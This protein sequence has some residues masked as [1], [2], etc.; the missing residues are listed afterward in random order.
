[1]KLIVKWMRLLVAV[2][3]IVAV[4]ATFAETAMRV[5]VN[6]FNFF[7]YFTIQSNLIIAVV[8]LVTTARS[9]NDSRGSL[10]L[11]RACAT[12]Y[13][14]VVGIVYALLLAPLGAA[15]GVPLPWANFILH[16]LVPL[17]AVADW[18]LV[19]DRLRVPYRSLWVAAV[20]PLL[21]CGVVLARGATDGWVPYPFLDPAN[22]YASVVLYVAIIAAMVVAIAAVVF[23]I[24]RWRGVLR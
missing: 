21:W 8:Y 6:P 5:S 9:G 10:T 16:I 11:A 20:Y 14:I 22:G 18:S 3:I 13:L 1:V 23:W 19:R 15:G 2:A 4:V 7:G 17:Y 24:S 12:T